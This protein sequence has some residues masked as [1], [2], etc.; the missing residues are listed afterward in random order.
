MTP[1]APKEPMETP[2]PR[3]FIQE[4]IDEDCRT[5]RWGVWP[6]SEGPVRH[7]RPRVHT[8]FPP[9]P[10]GY[11]HIGHAKSICLNYGLAVEYGGK[12]NLR[13]DDTNPLKEEQEYVDSIIRDVCWLVEGWGGDAPGV[14][15]AL[16]ASDYFAQMHAWAVE[17]I[18]KGKAYVCDQSP[19]EM[20]E[21][22]GTLTR[23]GRNSP[24]RERSIEENLDLFER[25]RQG[26]FP[27]GSRT[28][29]AK[30]HMA[31]PNLNLRDPVM[32]RILHATHHRT[33]DA[34]CIYPM[35]DWAHGLEDSLEGIT[36]SI[37]TLEFENHRPLYDWFIDAINEG[38]AADGAGPWGP[39][40]HHPQQIEF[41]RLNMTCT[42]MSKRKLLELVR[43]GHVR[44]WDDPRM[45]TL[46]AM[47]RRGYPAAAI[48]NFC[49]RVGVAKFNG[50]IEY[51]LLEHCVRDEL[52][53]SA[54]RVLAVLNPLKLVIVNW[55]DGGPADRVE[56]LE[57]VCNP[58][59]PAAGTRRV[60][61]TRELWI[62]Q[63]DFRESP[64][65][66]Y[67]RLFPGNE[68]RLRYGYLVRCTG[69]VKDGSGRV[70]EVHCT[71]DPATRGGDAPDGR[72]V[73]S[74]LHWVSASQAVPCEVRLY[75][76]LFTRPDPES[77]PVAA[78][79]QGGPEDWKQNLNP[80]SEEVR[81]AFAEPSLLQAA[82]G[83]V[84][85]FE[86]LGYFRL[87]EDSD[88][89]V[90]VPI[91]KLVFNRTVTLKDAWARIDRQA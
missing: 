33:G 2:R 37:C 21:Y 12:F 75:D 91:R 59:N 71:Y 25:M 15:P 45:P 47:R 11:L 79:Q 17:L 70:V 38:R 73:K 84:F 8:R 10:N 32:Y 5:Q 24:Y 81:S 22:R 90:G 61:F 4:I 14:G 20:R 64:P 41:A 3:N 6:A 23:P 89:G 74:T 53:R 85:Q 55:E 78:E 49:A 46:S 36:H 31:S 76:H 50:V 68:V 51:Q 57:A 88:A 66:K 42:L 18:R 80:A 27:D 63:D 72:K 39:P 40:I 13:F 60:P 52:N 56:W 62:D 30:I 29:R 65:P 83:E 28:L 77:G 9:E 19:E 35:Y 54:P 87:D 67:W 48:R 69:L 26:D 82:V 34:W 43:G 1:G 16:Y 86:R 44:G 58:E 7:G